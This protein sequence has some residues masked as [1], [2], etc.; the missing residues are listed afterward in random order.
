MN[1]NEVIANRAIEL[2][3]GVLGSKSPVHPND[4]VNMS[5]SSNDT[6]PTAMHIAAAS[7]AD[8][9]PAARPSGTC[10]TRW[11]RRPTRTP[12]STKIGR[13][14]LDGRGAPHARPGVLRV[15]RPARRRP[16]PDRAD[17][18]GPLRAGRRGTAVGTGLNTHPEFGDRVA[19]KIAESPGCRSSPHRTSSLRWPPTTRS[20]GRARAAHPRRFADEDRR[21]PPLARIGPRSGL[22]E[23]VLPANEPGSSIMP[24]KVNPTQSEAM[25]MVC[26]QV[27][28][29]DTAVGDRRGPGQPRAQRQ[30]AGHHP[31]HPALDR[32]ADRARAEASGCSA[33]TGSSRTSSRSSATSRT[34]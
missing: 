23:L 1:A 16:R 19:A 7:G 11:P 25:I 15:R 34:R 17:A 3:G 21:R 13:T 27:I 33:S 26:I 9:S 22:G 6:F 10:G 2:A 4:D 31:Q 20:S 30:Q 18:A 12:R 24:G 8:R 29:N 14:Q 5:Q 28:G 32:A